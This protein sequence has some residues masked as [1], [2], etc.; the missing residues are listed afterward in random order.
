MQWLAELII[1]VKKPDDVLKII[2]G[3]IELMS[4]S[5]LSDYLT[6]YIVMKY[7]NATEDCAANIVSVINRIL[8]EGHHNHKMI[9]TR[10]LIIL[11]NW[12]KKELKNEKVLNYDPS[13]PRSILQ[14]D[15]PFNRFLRNFANI[16]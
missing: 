16:K 3:C 7:L 1:K 14:S 2:E 13:N 15:A 4:N 11:E 6:P 8:E 5:D 9:I 12:F 10:T